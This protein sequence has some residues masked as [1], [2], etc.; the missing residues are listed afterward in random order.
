MSPELRVL[1]SERVSGVV[2]IYSIL[3]FGLDVPIGDRV[4]QRVWQY[5]ILIKD[6]V[7]LIY[8]I[9]YISWILIHTE[10]YCQLFATDTNK[11]SIE[12]N[13]KK[14]SRSLQG[15]WK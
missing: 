13:E 1:F 4:R 7:G 8:V 14:Y 15:V 5:R 11:K 2:V 9:I 3:K 12:G 6:R 10:R